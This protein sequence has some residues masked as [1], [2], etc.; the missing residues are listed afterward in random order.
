MHLPS[1]AFGAVGGFMSED[2][3]IPTKTNRVRRLIPE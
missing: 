3:K 1:T 2:I